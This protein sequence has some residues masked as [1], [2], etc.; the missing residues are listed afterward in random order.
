MN[1]NWIQFG[2]PVTGA[3]PILVQPNE[4][5]FEHGAWQGFLLGDW[6]E[7][8]VQLSEQ[9]P[10][11]MPREEAEENPEYQQIIPW[12]VFRHGHDYLILQKPQEGPHT[13]LYGKNSIGFGGHV[14]QTEL[15]E[16]GDLNTWVI[17]RFHNEMA[18]QGN[19][20]ATVIGVV[21]DNTDDL[22]KKH[23]GLVYL[24]EGDTDQIQSHKGLALGLNKLTDLTLDD[25]Q[26][27]DR[28]SQMVVR[29]LKDIERLSQEASE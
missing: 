17:N 20:T 27:M 8:F 16:F 4:I 22:G 24:L 11:W 18:Y 9:S 21:N 7:Y 23:F 6:G 2:K 29:Q 10:Q 26:Y 5:I 3:Q 13:R 12:C 14:L 25:M 28:W 15:E 19:L 1:N